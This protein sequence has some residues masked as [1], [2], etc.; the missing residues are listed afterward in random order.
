MDEIFGEEN[1]VAQIA[2]FTTTSQ[3]SRYL[4]P[5]ADFLL[6]YSRSR[7]GLKYQP[8]LNSKDRE[9]QASS[10]FALFEDDMVVRRRP[11]GASAERLLVYDNLTSRSGSGA[12]VLPFSARGRVFRPTTGGW[13]TGQTGLGRLDR[14]ARIGVRGS[15]ALYV[16]YFDDF[17]F[18]PMTN[19]WRD[20]QSRGL[21]V[22]SRVYVVQTNVRVMERCVL[23]TTDPGDLVLDPTCGSGTTAMLPNNGAAAGSPSTHPVSPS[24][25]RARG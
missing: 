12:A 4:P 18:V 6:W 22:E 19:V 1:F 24:H 2:F 5:I 3:T 25:W 17:P 16:R 20:T 13:R 11:T 8:I 15:G 9:A 10:A 14:A 21:G 23:M 7:D